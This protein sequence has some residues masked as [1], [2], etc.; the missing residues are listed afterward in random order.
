MLDRLRALE[1][2]YPFVGDV[3]GKG[4]F[5]G[6]ELV[7]DKDTKEPLDSDTTES[8]FREALRRGLLLMGYDYRIRINPALNISRDIASAGIEVL[9]EVFDGVKRK[10]GL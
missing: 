3:R 7:K 9:D 1:I 4:L 2:K 5:I 10:L 8:I 6:L